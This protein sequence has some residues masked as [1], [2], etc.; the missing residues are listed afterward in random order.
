MLLMTSWKRKTSQTLSNRIKLCFE[1]EM[2]LVSSYLFVLLL[3]SSIPVLIR[4]SY[5]N[6]CLFQHEWRTL[7]QLCSKS[8]HKKSPQEQDKD[9]WLYFTLLLNH[10]AFT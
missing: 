9:D 3:V 8:Q 7:C 6:E 1:H 10:A 2:Y 4:K 5:Y